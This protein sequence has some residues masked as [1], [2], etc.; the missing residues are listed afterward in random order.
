MIYRAG[1]TH[2]TISFRQVSGNMDAIRIIHNGETMP[3]TA[4]PLID[5]GLPHNVEVVIG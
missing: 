1:K 4:I 5:D 2:Y 3:S